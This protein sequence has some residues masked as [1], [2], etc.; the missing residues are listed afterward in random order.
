VLTICPAYIA[1]EMTARNPYRCHSGSMPM[2]PRGG[3]LRH[4][5]RRRFYVLPWPMA[6]VGRVLRIL[7]ADLRR[8]LRVR[9]GSRAN[10][11][12]GIGSS[13]ACVARLL[14]RQPQP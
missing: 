3:S 12:R 9:R 6:V 8:C 14:Q 10:P 1:T 2:K 4:E 7:R 13:L 5:R 11:V